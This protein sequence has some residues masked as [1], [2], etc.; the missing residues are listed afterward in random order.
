MRVRSVHAVK[1]GDKHFPG[2][3]AEAQ[4]R[5]PQHRIRIAPATRLRNSGNSVP[6]AG[7]RL[8]TIQ[9][10]DENAGQ[11]NSRQDAD[12][13]RRD[14]QPQKPPHA[15]KLGRAAMPSFLETCRIY[16]TSACNGGTL[17][18]FVA[19]AVHR[20]NAIEI[21]PAGQYGD[22]TKR[23]ARQY[24]R[25]HALARVRLPH[26]CGKRNNPPDPPRD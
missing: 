23:R 15:R 2:S 11:I 18:A 20:G 14:A 3:T 7:T 21:S 22:I 9:P 19:G 1:P 5:N 4:D 26:R 16:G 6:A 17:G 12:A 24:F 13:Q 8:A 25:V 10:G